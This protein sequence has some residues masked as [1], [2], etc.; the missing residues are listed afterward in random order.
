[1]SQYSAEVPN[2]ELVKP[3]IK[4]YYEN[5]YAVS[6]TPDAHEKYA[7]LFTKDARLIM[8]SKGV[9]GRD[10]ILEMRKGMW[11]KVAKRSH[12]PT[13]IFSFGAGTNE[14]MLFGTVDYE[15]KDGKKTTVEWSARAVF[16][17]EDGD[18]KMSFY[19]VYLDTAA[20]SQAK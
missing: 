16:T 8:A 12:K 2:D 14:V 4:S 3:E 20:M 5:F 15:L 11:E 6:D 7:S 17:E 18:L 19:Q 10:E 13:K 9:S 1:M